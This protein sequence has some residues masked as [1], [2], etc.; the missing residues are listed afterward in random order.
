MGT[1]RGGEGGEKVILGP[2]LHLC[3]R[4]RNPA[5]AQSGGFLGP[6]RPPPTAHPS[7]PPK[8][9][10]EKKK[11][12]ERRVVSSEPDPGHLKWPTACSAPAKAF[13]D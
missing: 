13:P 4:A 11:K 1:G 9:K 7:P 10:Q 6:A 12:E 3:A 8:K 2:D 5:E